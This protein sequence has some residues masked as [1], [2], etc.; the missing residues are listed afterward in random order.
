MNP[1]RSI[2][3]RV[4]IWH[5]LILGVALIGFGWTAWRLQETDHFRRIDTQL[6][7]RA[8]RLAQ[9]ARDVH[10]PP[11]P[12]PP[13]SGD[14]PTRPQP[15]SKRRPEID[16]PETVEP[17]ARTSTDLLAA[18]ESD[19]VQEG[20]YHVL[21]HRDGE[22]DAISDDA[23]EGI[24]YPQDNGRPGTFRS[25][26]PLREFYHFGP[27]GLCVLAGQDIS[28][29]LA[30][31]RRYAW[32]LTGAGCVVLVFGLVGGWW[33]STR[34]IRP[35]KDISAT[36]IKISNGDLSQRIQ[37]VD[38]DSEL[39]AL[40]G[41]LNQTFARLQT[42]FMRQAQFTA[43]ASHELRTPVTVL[44]TET[45]SVLAR[46]RSA[47]EYQ[48]SLAACQRAARRMRRLIESMLALARV[49]S[50]ETDGSREDCALGR[51]VGSAVDQLR[52]LAAEEGI[53]LNIDCRP[54]RCICVKEQVSQI[55]TNLVS[56]AIAY[57]HPGGE[58]AV[59]VWSEAPFARVEVRDT[60]I[61]ISPEDLPHIFKRFYRADKARTQAR[62]RSGLGLAIT[63]A[64]VESHGGQ[65]LAESAIGEGSTFTVKLPLK[66]PA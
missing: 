57:N 66:P 26:G 31:M 5:G 2:R 61:G 35:I 55:V 48:Q 24:P 59:K 23:P 47:D 32:V 50:G 44:L 28:V 30:E 17:R 60:G 16:L 27:G 37:G 7:Q 65:I 4:Q 8:N 34:A 11:R 36:A 9:L 56:N 12:R 51:L 40:A 22:I 3:W 63:A 29:D 45:Q 1:L 41:I 49:D 52:P 39:G 6:E 54:V 21:W 64:I 38:T 43:D 20:L 15:D 53:Q 46:E 14:Y 25:R 33:L 58:I 10:R 19:L 42:N 13:P 18:F 62:G